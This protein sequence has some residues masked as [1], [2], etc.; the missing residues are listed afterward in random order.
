MIYLEDS[1]NHTLYQL[2]YRLFILCPRLVVWGFFLSDMFIHWLSEFDISHPGWILKWPHADEII[3]CFRIIV[4][5]ITAVFVNCLVCLSCRVW[6][7]LVCT[8]PWFCF[9]IAGKMYSGDLCPYLIDIADNCF[10]ILTSLF[11]IAVACKRTCASQEA[12]RS[13]KWEGLAT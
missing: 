9:S 8:K 5:E 13:C 6:A 1:H 7:I 10:S 2:L 11:L 12:Y 4:F 3:W